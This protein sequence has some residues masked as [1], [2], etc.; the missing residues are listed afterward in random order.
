M[1]TLT[2]GYTFGASETV[3]NAKLHSLVTGATITSLVNA[4]IDAAAAIAYSK[5]SLSNSIVNADVSSAAAIA[6]S[7]L[8]LSSIAQNVVFAGTVAADSTFGI[9]SSAVAFYLQLTNAETLTANRM[10]TIKLNDA[11]RTLDLGG[12]LTLAA[13]FTTSGANALTLTTTGSTNV[14]LPTTGTLATLAGTETLASKTLTS[15]ILRGVGVA[16]LTDGATVALDASLGNH[17][18][19]SAGGN[20]T[21]LA[22]TN[23]TSRQKIIIE[24]VASGGARTLSLT[25]GSAGAFRFGT[26]VTALTETTSGKT[27]YIGCIYNS[28]DSRWDVVAY[29]KGY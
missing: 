26:D 6:N 11:A 15:P 27:D 28:D 20:R 5:L 4:D 10:L 21:I 18:R 14:T 2:Q 9:K 19:L 16:T 29:V 7:K 12:T 17:F 25:T 23:A 1:A 24:H 8:N 3:T 13:A 22:P